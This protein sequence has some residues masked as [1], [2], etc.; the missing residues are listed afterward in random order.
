MHS[1]TISGRGAAAT[2]GLSATYNITNFGKAGMVILVMAVGLAVGLSIG[3][4]VMMAWGQ[5]AHRDRVEAAQ[6]A[7]ER[8]LMD[9]LSLADREARIAMDEVQRIKAENAARL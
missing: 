4:V 1:E 6:L 8:R 9:R 5:A 7:M 2:G 3:A